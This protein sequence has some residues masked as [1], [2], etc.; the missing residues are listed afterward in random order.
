M[1]L[2]RITEHV[3]D[4]NWF[5]VAIDFLIVVIGVFIGLQVANWN[6][7]RYAIKQ[8]AALIERLTEEFGA[9]E[10]LLD[11]RIERAER[12]TRHTDELINIVRQDEVPEDSER[13]RL[14]LTDATRYNGRV[15]PPNTYAEALQSGSIGNIRNDAI[16]NALS[17]YQNSTYWWETVTG[18]APP[19]IDA[20]S[21]LLNGITL[22]HDTEAAGGAVYSVQAFDWPTISKAETELLVIHR[23]QSFQ[24]EAFRLER[25]SVKSV[26]LA[27]ED[28]Q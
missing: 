17:D 19:Q 6:E 3:K 9:L 5:A 26:L 4:Q 21:N 14:M 22:A 12:L 28:N 10:D 15:A 23:R 1:I 20:N 13:I 24:A 11:Q 7:A 27:L 2:R 16:R 25:E 18:P 8:E